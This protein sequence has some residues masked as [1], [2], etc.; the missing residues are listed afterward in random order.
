[1][2]GRLRASSEDAGGHAMQTP[3]EVTA[4][5]EDICGRLMLCGCLVQ[6]PGG[7]GCREGLWRGD[8]GG[9]GPGLQRTAPSTGRAWSGGKRLLWPLVEQKPETTR[10]KDKVSV[11]QGDG[12]KTL[13]TAKW[14][15][16]DKQ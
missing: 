5:W 4:A 16:H 3:P 8:R 11:L 2:L 12:H 1:M 13:A 15:D 6:P 14:R 7:A 10:G 9:R